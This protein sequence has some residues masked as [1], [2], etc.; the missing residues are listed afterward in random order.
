MTTEQTTDLER[1]LIRA[2][3]EETNEAIKHTGHTWIRQAVEEIVPP[4]VEATLE[5]LGIDYRNPLES[6]QDFAH[7][8]KSRIESED[9]RKV[10]IASLIRWGA[11]LGVAGFISWIVNNANLK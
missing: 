1:R 7:L 9:R 3:R 5:R 2:I 11:P 4:T 10:F 8:R 6:Q